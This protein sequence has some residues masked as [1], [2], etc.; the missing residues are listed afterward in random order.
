LV[1]GVTRAS[2]FP[3]RLAAAKE[4]NMTATLTT[5]CGSLKD[6][7][8]LLGIRPHRIDHAIAT[9]LVAEPKIRVANRRVFQQEDVNTLAK[10]FGI[11]LKN[12]KAVA[13]ETAE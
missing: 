7:S 2:S 8:K 5:W 3:P 13:A 10:H 1:L 9:G 11:K 6:V 12:A 4:S